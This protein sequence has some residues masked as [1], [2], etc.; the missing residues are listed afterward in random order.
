MNIA[1][2]QLDTVLTVGPGKIT[3]L[4]IE[5]K[6][7]FREML[8]DVARQLE[9]ADGKT[10]L[11]D[12]GKI[13]PLSK[14]AELI[15]SFVNFS[16]NT[17]SLQTKIIAAME[18]SAVGEQHY[19]E[20]MTLLNRLEE[21]V[22][23]LTQDMTADIVCGKLSIG[24]V[25][26]SIGISVNDDYDDP[27]ERLLDYMELVREFDRDKL[28]IYVNLR[29]YFDDEELRPFL[30]TVIAHEYNILLVDS[31]AG[32]LLPYEDRLTVDNDLCEF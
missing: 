20:C 28:F 1:H 17:K 9:G 22:L 19:L 32:A 13:L 3:T 8:D 2:I 4:V 5:N 31:F 7:F 18:K 30:E 25:L 23:K 15:D 12:N 24:T 27:L 11:S 16:V 21:F 26:K 10:V 29:A 6:R 14:N